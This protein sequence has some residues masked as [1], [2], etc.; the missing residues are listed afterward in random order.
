MKQRAPL[1]ILCLSACVALI[2]ACV[3]DKFVWQGFQGTPVHGLR[4]YTAELRTSDIRGGAESASGTLYLA[5]GALRYEMQGAGP[6]EHLILLARLDA[7]QAWLVNPSGGKCLEGSFAPRRWMDIGYLL[8]AFPKVMLPRIIAH[9]EELLGT[10]TLL[11]YKVSKI[12][13][14]GREV[15]FG[16]ERDFTELFWLAEEFCVPLRHE[17]GLIRSDLTKIREQASADSLFT[18]PAG[19]RKASSFA[20]LL[21]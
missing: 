2:Y 19:C 17:N 14:T 16:E 18:L 7:G 15:L 6:L 9:S 21:Q 4:A 12:R 3:T 11:G 8:G 10:E 5:Q 20:D 13:R 1:F